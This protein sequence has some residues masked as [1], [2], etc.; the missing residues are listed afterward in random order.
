MV[1]KDQLEQLGLHTLA[2]NLGEVEIEG[3]LSK[4]QLLQ[5]DTTLKSVGFEL[6]DNKKAR[7]SKN[8]NRYRNTDPSFRPRL[9][10]K[11]F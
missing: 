1:V 5:L 10:D 8:K 3:N 2:V 11:P 7:S 9:K 6:I 4:D